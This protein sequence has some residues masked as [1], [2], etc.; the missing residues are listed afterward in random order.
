M[1]KTHTCAKMGPEQVCTEDG[2]QF[3]NSTLSSAHSEMAFSC[4]LHCC[5]VCGSVV[6]LSCSSTIRLLL[7]C[8]K[9]KPETLENPECMV[10]L[11]LRFS[12]TDSK[13]QLFSVPEVLGLRD[14]VPLHS[15]PQ[16]PKLAC[17][18]C[19]HLKR[20]RLGLSCMPAVIF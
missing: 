12:D 14:W 5:T 17:G 9:K 2:R 11:E 15:L 3:F 6:Q 4:C 7:L 19:E 20:Q 13:P 8:A 10:Q 1:T 18:T 16:D